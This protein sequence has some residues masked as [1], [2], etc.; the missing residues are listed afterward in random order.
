MRQ[1]PLKMMILFALMMTTFTMDTAMAHRVIAFASYDGENVTVECYFPGGTPIKQGEIEVEDSTG[2]I[3]ATGKTDQKGIFSFRPHGIPPLSIYV[4]AGPGHLA[5]TVI[6]PDLSPKGETMPGAVPATEENHVNKVSRH[7]EK[8][9]YEKGTGYHPQLSQIFG[10]IRGIREDVR[11]LRKEQEKV[12]TR[13][14]LGGMGY[15]LGIMGI[16]A[17]MK[18]RRDK[19]S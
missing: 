19:E 17:F 3:V 6:D 16:W 15:I 14:I 1:K 8:A 12:H 7:H 9:G 18:A 13:D 4:E 10:A 5:K 11:E 2:K